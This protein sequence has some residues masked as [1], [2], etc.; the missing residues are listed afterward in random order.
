MEVV[1]VGRFIFL[2]M[3]CISLGG[4]FFGKGQQDEESLTASTDG[5]KGATSKDG[6]KAADGIP[7]PPSKPL[8]PDPCTV[9]EK[10]DGEPPIYI[11]E[12]NVMVTQIIKPCITREGKT[13]FHKKTPWMAMGFPC[14]GGGGKVALIGNYYNPKMVSF[15]ISSDCPMSPNSM[16]LVRKSVQEAAGISD[17]M[18]LLSFNSFV[19]QFW[20]VP[21]LSD[22]DTGFTIDL[23]SPGGI[24]GAWKRMRKQEPLRVW[25]FGRE[26]AWTSR[27]QFYKVVADLTLSGSRVFNMKVVSAEKLD[28]EALQEVKARCDA[29]RPRRNCM[30]VF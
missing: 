6:K 27:D 13:G 26:N 29:L 28:K 7:K 21:G 20:E 14:T 4:C 5:D 3:V 19:V 24:E 10:V 22:S 1:K 18:K 11:P 9:L 25:L 17:E 2:T 12:K 30:H 8:P 23:T 16:D 15:I